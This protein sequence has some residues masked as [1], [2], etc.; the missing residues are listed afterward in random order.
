MNNNKTLKILVLLFL[1]CSFTASVIAAK[2]PQKNLD[3]DPK[4]FNGL[5]LA[6]GVQTIDR[7]THNRG[8]IFTT[9]DNYG[10]I[11]GYSYYDLPSGEWPKNSGHDYIAEILYWVGA[12]LPNGDTVVANTSD[13]FQ[14][15]Q[16]PVNGTDEYLIYLSSD[17][18]R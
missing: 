15:I 11:G 7:I 18:S 8:N 12:T 1:V 17:T 5:S 6:P 2:S 4:N 3:S 14:A 10:Y 9:I 16:M 13:D